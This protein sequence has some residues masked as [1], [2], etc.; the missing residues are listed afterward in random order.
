MTTETKVLYGFSSRQ[1][2]KYYHRVMHYQRFTS[3][4]R[5]FHTQCVGDMRG[6][7]VGN[8]EALPSWLKP[9]PRC[10]K[11]GQQ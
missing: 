2:A 10:F 7:V 4:I 11:G 6:L 9:C 8:I 1:N 3:P 5:I